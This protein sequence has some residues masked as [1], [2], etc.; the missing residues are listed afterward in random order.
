M[1]IDHSMCRFIDGDDPVGALPFHMTDISPM[2]L[3]NVEAM[4]E[5]NRQRPYTSGLLWWVGDCRVCG[6]PLY[7]HP[8]HITDPYERFGKH[9]V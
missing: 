1:A 8:S 2:T 5:F 4:C 3:E 9:Y 7:A 6:R